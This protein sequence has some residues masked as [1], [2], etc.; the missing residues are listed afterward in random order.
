MREINMEDEIIEFSGFTESDIK[1]TDPFPIEAKMKAK[2]LTIVSG[3]NNVGKSLTNKLIWL[4]TTFI[5]MKITQACE[6][7]TENKSDIEM[8][9]FLLDNTFDAPDFNGEVLFT[10]REQL[11]NVAFFSIGYSLVDGKIMD[12]KIDFPDDAKPM[13]AIIYLSKDARDFSNIEK[14]LKLKKLLQISDLDSWENLEKLGDM[15]KIYDIISIENLLNKIDNI[16][17]VLKMLKQSNT[18]DLLGGMDLVSIEYDK[19]KSE[20][21]YVSSNNTKKRLSTVGLGTQSILT[22]LINAI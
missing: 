18:E 15:Y 11:L 19:N 7:V 16:N 21:Y 20:L 8:L 3:T 6:Q 17:P 9:Q 22:M 5:N 13:G 10:T 2:A 12:L 1:L 14:Y 4:S